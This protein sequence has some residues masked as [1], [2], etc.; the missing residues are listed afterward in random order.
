MK[1]AMIGFERLYV[2]FGNFDINDKMIFLNKNSQC[3][4]WF[5]Q[6]LALNYPASRQATTQKDMLFQMIKIF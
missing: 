2:R 6:N 4:V 5:H 3:R 1:E